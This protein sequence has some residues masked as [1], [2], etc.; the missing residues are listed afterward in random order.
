MHNAGRVVTVPHDQVHD[1]P[2]LRGDVGDDGQRDV[3]QVQLA[4]DLLAQAQQ[5]QAEPVGLG[6]RVLLN[7]ASCRQRVQD[8]KDPILAHA[9]PDAHFRHALLGGRRVQKALKH[10]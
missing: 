7:V 10:G 8:S 1:F 5:H 2:G 4:T 3:I 9:Q 6:F